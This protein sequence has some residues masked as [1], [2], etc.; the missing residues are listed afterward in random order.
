MGRAYLLIQRLRSS[1]PVLE[2][3][4]CVEAEVLGLGDELFDALGP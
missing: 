1:S 4:I 2:W 3:N